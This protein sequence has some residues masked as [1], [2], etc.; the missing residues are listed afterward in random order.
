[1]VRGLQKGPN[2]HS[3][4]LKKISGIIVPGNH[5]AEQNK[6]KQQ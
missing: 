1:M 3:I 5:H 6:K 2:M 4:G